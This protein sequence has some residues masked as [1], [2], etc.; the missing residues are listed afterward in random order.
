[1]S[2]EILISTD[3]TSDTVTSGDPERM[4]LWGQSAGAGAVNA[5]GYANP[6]D[7]IVTGLISQSGT[8]SQI[9]ASNTTAFTVLAEKFG[10]GGLDAKQEL[11]CMQAVDS[12]ELHDVIRHGEGVPRFSPVAD[13]VTVYENNTARLEKGF[14]AKVVSTLHWPMLLP[15]QTDTD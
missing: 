7:A 12:A 14:V 1:V 6:E 13:N 4:V 8:S 10:C 11:A 5:Y 2:A 9:S 3:K 15:H